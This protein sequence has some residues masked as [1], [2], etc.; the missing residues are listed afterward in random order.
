MIRLTITVAAYE[1]IAATLPS[2]VGVE[3]KRAA[4]GDYHIWLEPRFIDR[5]RA[6]RGP[7]ESYSDVILRLAKEG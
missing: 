7:S 3:Q 4:N 2:S 5:L 1:A 6:M